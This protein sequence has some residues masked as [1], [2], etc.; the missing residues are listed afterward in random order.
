MSNDLNMD[1]PPP[2]ETNAPANEEQLAA[3][4]DMSNVDIIVTVSEEGAHVS[5]SSP[6]VPESSIPGEGGDA[7]V[8]NFTAPPAP[9]EGNHD[10]LLEDNQIVVSVDLATHE[11]S[12]A[13]DP[14]AVNGHEGQKREGGDEGGDGV[15]AGGEEGE[16]KGYDIRSPFFTRASLL[17]EGVMCQVRHVAVVAK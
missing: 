9:V 5:D 16:E 10:S 17:A 11:L 8:T 15:E 6:V 12:A 13:H 4:P 14:E 3:G 7:I 1:Q 2:E